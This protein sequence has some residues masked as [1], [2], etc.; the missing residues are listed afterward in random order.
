MDFGVQIPIVRGIPDSMGWIPKPWIPQAKI[1]RIPESE[2]P[3]RANCLYCIFNHAYSVVIFYLSQL[4]YFKMLIHFT[5]SFDFSLLNVYLKNSCIRGLKK[6][7]LG[8]CA[9][10][11]GKLKFHEY[12]RSYENTCRDFPNYFSF[13]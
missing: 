1:S 2:L 5:K 7:S 4:S 10:K 9:N 12:L 3:H 11:K 8:S 13:V 6:L